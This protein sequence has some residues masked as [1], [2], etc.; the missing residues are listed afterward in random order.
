MADAVVVGGGLGA[1]R[2][3]AALRAAGHSVVLLQEGPHLAGRSFPDVPVGTGYERFARVPQGWRPVE[4]ATSGLFVGGTLHALP[5]SRAVLPRL[6]PAAQVG[7]AVAAWGRARGQRELAKLIGGG[8]ECRTYR[9]WIVQHYGEPIYHRLFQPYAERRFGD[10]R[11]VTANVARAVH[12]GV[13][14]GYL[15][16]PAEGRA[17]ELVAGL[18]GVEVR[19]NV[20]VTGLDGGGVNTTEGQVNGDVYVD[21]PPARVVAL[22]GERAPNGV[23]EEV[24][25]LRMRHAL[26][27]TLEGG[28]SLPWI[29]HDVDGPGQAFRLV[30]HGLFPGSGHLQGTVSVQMSVEA[31]DPL[32]LGSDAEAI[33]AAMQ[34][35]RELAPDVTAAG[36]RVQR[37]VNQHPVWVTTTAARMRRYVLMLSD[38]KVVPVGR[39]G[40]YSTLAG[41]AEVSYLEAVIGQGVPVRDAFR[42]HVEPPVVVDEVRAHLTDFA[43]D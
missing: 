18:A 37:V 41:E 20:T 33:D 26:E 14:E 35:A 4:G 38:L 1:V 42:R 43:V 24:S 27:V 9:D 36:A 32:W 25:W 22:L 34:A 17:A 30:R 19:T 11:G 2:A 39:A 16:C 29:T 3:A 10:P 6:F 15:A 8:K 12:G 5:L 23:A 13:P 40:T 31:N 7:A 28:A 21:L